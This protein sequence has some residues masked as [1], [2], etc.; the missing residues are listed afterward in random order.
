MRK[1]FLKKLKK[2]IS[3]AA[4][5]VLAMTALPVMG[6]LFVANAADPEIKESVKT[7]D[8]T[9]EAA[10][11]KYKDG[12]VIGTTDM[13]VKKALNINLDKGVLRFR[14]G[15][16]ILMPV[17]DDTTK[18]EFTMVCNGDKADRFVILGEDTSDTTYSCAMSKAG[19]SFTVGDVTDYIVEE[20]GKKYIP[21]ISNGD[22]K[23]TS[24]T[25]KEYNPVNRVTVTGKIEG[26]AAVGIDSVKFVNMDDPKAEVITAPV[27][28]EGKYTATLRRVDG[29][30]N[31]FAAVSKL[32]YKID[33]TDGA[34]RFTL[35]GNGS[36]AEH[37]FK[38]ADS[39]VATIS[40]GTFEGVMDADLKGEIK[41]VFTPKDSTMDSYELALQKVEDGKYTFGEIKITANVDYEAVITNADDYEVKAAVNKA[42]G[43]YADVVIKA[44][45]K[46]VYAVSGT[47]V[48][49]DDKKADVKSITFKNM[50][51]PDYSYTFSVNGTTYSAALRDGEYETSV[52]C[53]GY[54]AYDH[55]SV[56]GGLV[57]N[58]VYLV[59]GAAEPVNAYAAEIKVGK[60]EDIKTIADAVKYISNMTRT[61]DQRVTIVLM[62]DLYREQL[63]IDTPNITLKSNNENG[64]TIT[65]YYGVGY[66]YYSAKISA[67]KRSAYYDEAWAV[68]KYY[69]TSISQNPGHWGATVNL[70]AGA[71]GFKAENITFE[72]SFNRYMTTEEVADGVSKGIENSKIDRSTAKDA[73]VITRAAKER[74]AAL[75]IQ[76]DDTEYKNCK[77]LSSQDTLYTGDG[78]ESSYFTDCVIEGSTDYICGDGNAVF[79][80]CTLS[81]YGYSDEEASGSLIVANKNTG[82]HGYLFYNCDIVNTDYPGILPTA[83]FYFARSWAR[84]CRNTFI[85][86]TV[87]SESMIVPAGYTNMSGD[88]NDV[89]DSFMNEFGTHTADGVMVATAERCKGTKIMTAAEAAAVDPKTFFDDFDATYYT[90]VAD[91][92]SVYKAM[93]EAA[94]YDADKYENFDAVNKAIAAV[95]GSKKSA[96]Q[97][98]VEAMAK[99][100]NDAIGALV[101]KSE[102]VPPAEEPTT[103]PVVDEPT[104]PSEP[105]S[106]DSETPKTGDAAPVALYVALALL[107]VLALAGVCVLGK[108]KFTK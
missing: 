37:N 48:A 106:P 103:P 1:S 99:A 69:Q 46:P 39:P 83:S 19:N 6:G 84:G 71:K 34:N 95:D 62:D 32:G 23:A 31:Y 10:S 76:A 4:V 108:K 105:G 57:L 63:V 47:F 36:A 92:T 67:D 60:N 13:I 91:Y 102:V 73:D 64:S 44:E 72:N 29:N 80:N 53:D 81:M 94:K 70:F 65:W 27:D 9:K 66:S 43:T 104:Q 97:T 18:I 98:E 87:E 16:V 55:V 21:L 79:D 26:A 12:D 42:E 74:A 107:S 40:N 22:V 14:A 52:E 28:A 90:A 20:G 54:T 33:N 85:N 82:K 24:F 30:T 11:G 45:K 101:E 38:I 88:S 59:S 3:V 35:T 68:D 8:I 77:L 96:Q 78:E 50:D 100:I 41:V 7:Y 58:D 86:T 56:K 49:S 17:K 61:D 51:T 75:Y 2:G 25:L 5:A 93:E 15:N 89:S